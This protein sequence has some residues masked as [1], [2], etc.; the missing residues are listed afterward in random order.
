M[1]MLKKTMVIGSTIA[2]LATIGVTAF[3]ASTYQTPAE[4][5]AGLT[6][7]TVQ[8]VVDVR[9]ETGKTYGTIAKEAGKLE[10]FKKEVLEVKKDRYAQLVA[11]GKMTQAQADAAIAAIEENQATCDGTG[12]GSCGMRNGSGFGRGNGN[13][14]GFGRG[15]RDGSCAAQ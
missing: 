1:N 5:V 14:S 2:L 8:E 12:G 4:A 9:T 3:A 11:D 13:G 7:R 6:E 10:E 15:L